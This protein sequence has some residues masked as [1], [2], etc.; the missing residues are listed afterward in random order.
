MH[1][2]GGPT[3]MYS[4]LISDFHFNH[5]VILSISFLSV[6]LSLVASTMGASA[7]SLLC[8]I[9]VCVCVCVCVC[10]VT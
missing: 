2:L 8:Q 1:L 10:N 7:Y 4:S 3:L 9:N 5:C 6:S